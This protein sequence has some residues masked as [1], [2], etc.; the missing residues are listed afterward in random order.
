VT[1]VP[2][3][4]AFQSAAEFEEASR[5]TVK[6]IVSWLRLARSFVPVITGDI[7]VTGAPQ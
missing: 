1:A 2:K 4:L 6:V 3:G 5:S 7:H